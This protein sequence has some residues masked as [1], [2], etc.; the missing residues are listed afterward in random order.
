[1]WSVSTV[2]KCIDT[3]MTKC[4]TKLRGMYIKIHVQFNITSLYIAHHGALV[5][6][7]WSPT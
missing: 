3:T 5:T 7:K 6:C 1:M 4:Q 2:S